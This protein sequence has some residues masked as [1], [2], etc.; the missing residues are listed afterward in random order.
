MAFSQ[1]ILLLP[2]HSLEDFPTHY[3]GDDADGL[4]SAWCCG[5][6]PQILAASGALPQWTRAD[7]PPSDLAEPLLIIPS[8]AQSELPTGLLNK[9]R[10]AGATVVTQAPFDEMV[11]TALAGLPREANATTIVHEETVKDFF[12]LAY[13]YLQIELLTRQMRYACNLDEA[14]FADEVVAAAQFAL[15]GDEEGCREKLSRGFD[16]ISEERD[17]YYSVEAYL[18]DI[19]LVAPT[20]IGGPLRRQLESEV[21]T[22]L[23]LCGSTLEAI[24]SKSP[25]GFP[26]ATR[27]TPDDLRSTNRRPDTRPASDLDQT[28]LHGRFSLLVGRWSSPAE[29]AS[30]TALGGSRR[31]RH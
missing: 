1:T 9:A 22:T 27:S 26:T 13:V 23:L 12:A 16:L 28:G 4:L 2:C 19:T 29:R 6:H 14:A 15:S 17:H 7:D 25:R 21:P 24:Q 31:H 20:T 30:Q 10:D 11:S 8:L 18:V 3:E 5:W